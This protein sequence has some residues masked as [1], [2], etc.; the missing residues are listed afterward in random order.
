MNVAVITISDS[1][2]RGERQDA[3]GPAVVARCQEL[4]W[5]CSGNPFGTRMIP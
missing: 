2:A 4:R 5:R 1:V 3:P